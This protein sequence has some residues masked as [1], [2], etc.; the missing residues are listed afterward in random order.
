MKADQIL[1]K[2][3]LCVEHAGIVYLSHSVDNSCVPNNLNK[4][5][6]GDEQFSFRAIK[7]LIRMMSNL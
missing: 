2:R 5:L 6:A 4:M 3:L 1:Q 7:K